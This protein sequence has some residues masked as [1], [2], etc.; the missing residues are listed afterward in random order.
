MKTNKLMLHM[1]TGSTGCLQDCSNGR[2]LVRLTETATICDN[3]ENFKPLSKFNKGDL[4]DGDFVETEVCGA[5]YDNNM[6]NIDWNDITKVTRNNEV[7]WERDE[8]SETQKIIAALKKRVL[9][10]RDDQHEVRDLFKRLEAIEA[11]RS[12]E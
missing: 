12:A 7:I 8:K 9:Y 11:K 4:R 6:H 1:P 2:L 5:M 10:L 3:E